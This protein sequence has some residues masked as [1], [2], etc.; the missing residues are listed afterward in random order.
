VIFG[1]PPK[2]QGAGIFEIVLMGHLISELTEAKCPTEAETP[3][4]KTAHR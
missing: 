4:E 1:V 2:N 3:R